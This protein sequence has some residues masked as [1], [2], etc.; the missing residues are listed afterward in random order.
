MQQ[1]AFVSPSFVVAIIVVILFLLIVSATFL[2]YQYDKR[3]KLWGIGWLIMVLLTAPSI[4]Y[5]S[6]TIDILDILAIIGIIVGSTL[7]LNGS[8]Q[9]SKLFAW[10]V[11]GL[12]IISSLVYDILILVLVV[13]TQVAYIAPEFYAGITGLVFIRVFR[14]HYQDK[15]FF[16]V[17]L[18]I[19]ALGWAVTSLGVSV[20]VILPHNMLL[21]YLSVQSVALTMIGLGIYGLAIQLSHSILERQNN[22]ALL[23]ASVVHH[24]IRNYIQLILQALELAQEGGPKKQEWLTVATQ[25]T[26]KVTDFLTEVRKVTSEIARYERIEKVVN[27]TDIIHSV[28]ELI[29]TVY[30]SKNIEIVEDLEQS[31]M[32][33][34]NDLVHQI[35]YNIIDNAI[36]HGSSFLGIK[37]KSESKHIVLTIEDRAGGLPQSLIDYIN[38]PGKLSK[39]PGGGLGLILIKGLA[40]LCLVTVHTENVIEN[41]QPVGCK[42]ELV[43]NK[44]YSNNT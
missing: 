36:K 23:L 1:V 7:M 30:E 4:V 3:M 22:F 28:T 9:A 6:S 24:D 42:Y 27:L 20:V 33:Y 40:S 2:T 18:S 44:A 16:R 8:I 35:I 26:T 11:Y 13:P 34:S 41:E 12:A 5:P 14:E 21:I 38:R 15:G 10:W 25:V 17:F 43:F 29:E 19:G 32:V 39:A 31:L 37:S